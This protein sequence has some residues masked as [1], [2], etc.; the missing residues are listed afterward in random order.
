MPGNP[1]AIFIVRFFCEG[2]SDK[3]TGPLPSGS[4]PVRLSR[5]HATAFTHSVTHTPAPS[6][7]S[8]K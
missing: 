8:K 1:D 5:I 4:G 7:A 3:L 6:Q 2:F